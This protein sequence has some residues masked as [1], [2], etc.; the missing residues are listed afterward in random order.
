VSEKR[1]LAAGVF[2]LTL[3]KICEDLWLFMINVVHDGYFLMVHILSPWT[4]QHKINKTQAYHNIASI[5]RTKIKSGFRS[6]QPLSFVA[7]PGGFALRHA[8][9]CRVQ[10]LCRCGGLGRWLLQRP[11]GQSLHPGSAQ[12]LQQRRCGLQAEMCWDVS[13]R[14]HTHKHMITHTIYI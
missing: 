12:S 11:R 1:T 13:S 2:S 7:A 5:F 6:W 4:I 14:A 8:L 9:R 10:D 3:V